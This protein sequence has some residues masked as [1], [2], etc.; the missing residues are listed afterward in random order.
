MGQKGRRSRRTGQQELQFRTWGGKRKGAGRPPKV[1]GRP[2][3]PHRKRE[4]FAVPLPVH[5]TLRMAPG[6]WNLRS[7][8]SLR[9]IENSLRLGADRFGARVIRF[10][11]QG[12]HIHLLVEAD[13]SAALLR[14]IKGLSVR[15][16]KGLNRMMG[17]SGRVL[18]DRYHAHV[19]RTPTE[20]K[21]AIA[22]IR[23]NARKHAREWGEPWPVGWVDPYSSESCR[24]S[25]LLPAPKGWLLRAGWR[26]AGRKAASSGP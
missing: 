22:Y 5:V 16:A 18:S 3:V 13:Q 14:A 11:I 17:R 9:V 8:R 10:S 24:L 25:A 23:E 12:N 4:A 6:V 21:R 7:R 19:L 2:G 1:A 26:R 20:V 15:I